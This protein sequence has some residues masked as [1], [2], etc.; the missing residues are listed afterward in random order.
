VAQNFSG[1]DGD[2]IG[3]ARQVFKQANYVTSIAN[4]ISLVI[5]NNHEMSQSKLHAY[6]PIIDSDLS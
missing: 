2:S 5:T 3:N 4:D 6:N 1:S